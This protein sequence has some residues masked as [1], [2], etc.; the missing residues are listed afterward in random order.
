LLFAVLIALSPLQV[1]DEF[2]DQ[3]YFCMA[4]TLQSQTDKRPGAQSQKH[5]HQQQ[6]QAAAA[7]EAEMG[8][9]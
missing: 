5:G 2:T 9:G 7:E 3:K 6:Q 4:T 8:R 1:C